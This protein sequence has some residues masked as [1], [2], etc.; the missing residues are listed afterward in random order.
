MKHRDLGC[1]RRASDMLVCAI[2]VG[3]VELPA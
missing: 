2:H 3:R 1:L